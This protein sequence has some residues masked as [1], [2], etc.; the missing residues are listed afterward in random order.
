MG[1]LRA[2]RDVFA[3]SIV[4]AV[5][6]EYLLVKVYVDGLYAAFTP[7]TSLLFLPLIA[8]AY[9]VYRRLLAFARNAERV[10]RAL[11]P[12]GIAGAFIAFVLTLSDATRPLAPPLIAIV[13][14]AELA[15]GVKLYRDIEAM[16]K[17]GASL[18]VAGMALFII[19]LPT[20]ILDHRAALAPIVFNA[21]KT[22]GLALLL[23]STMRGEITGNAL[24]VRAGPMPTAR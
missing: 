13:Y 18:F 19:T 10:A 15:V 9:L 20:A 23:Y 1:G 14:L 22:A 11:L 7:P 8:L 4:A 21:V 2:A 5:I 3:A 17:A 16:S 6:I 12:P 24:E